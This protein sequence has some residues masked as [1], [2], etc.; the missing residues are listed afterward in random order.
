MAAP[1]STPGRSRESCGNPTLRPRQQSWPRPE[2]LQEPNGRLDD[3]VA[4][5]DVRRV[6][7]VVEEQ[8]RHRSC[9]ARHNRIDLRPRPI[10]VVGTLQHEGGT[11]NRRKTLFD[12]PRPEFVAQPRSGP[13]LEKPIDIAAM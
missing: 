6:S 4:L 1:D 3:G 8:A 5:I 12:V 10:F 7:T 9:D 2:L 13:A 11:R